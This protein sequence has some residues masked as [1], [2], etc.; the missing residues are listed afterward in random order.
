MGSES[1]MERIM[2]GRPI[3]RPML[4]CLPLLVPLGVV[5][6]VTGLSFREIAEEVR[7]GRLRAYRCREGGQKKYFRADMLALA[8]LGPAG[9]DPGPLNP[10]QT[11]ANGA[12]PT[13]TLSTSGRPGL[14]PPTA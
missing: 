9:D 6:E 11:G 2:R 8:G 10:A 3:T 12:N 1:R 4:Q 5:S 14:T 7:S 13:P